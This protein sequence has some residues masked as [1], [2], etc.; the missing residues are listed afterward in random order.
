MK[1]RREPGATVV[2]TIAPGLSL[3]RAD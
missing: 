3:Q 2:S 1:S